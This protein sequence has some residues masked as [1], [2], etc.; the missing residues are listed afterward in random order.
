LK[1]TDTCLARLEGERIVFREWR[2]DEV[3]AM[4]CWLG[5][6]AVTR[7]LSWGSC[8]PT[9]YLRGLSETQREASLTTPN[10][11]QIFGWLKELDLLREA[12]AA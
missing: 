3:A 12:N 7:F 10:W 2:A 8:H 9:A 11:N 6:A 1:P 5:D 4:H